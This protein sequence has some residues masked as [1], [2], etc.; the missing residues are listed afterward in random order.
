MLACIMGQGHD[1][2]GD[3]DRLFSMDVDAGL[4]TCSCVLAC[5]G[6]GQGWL[7]GKRQIVQKS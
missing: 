7:L 5:L 3:R 4:Y 2:C 1:C 6:Q